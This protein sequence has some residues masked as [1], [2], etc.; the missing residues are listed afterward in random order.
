MGI[1]RLL[2]SE[3]FLQ[4]GLQDAGPDAVARLVDVES[5]CGKVCPHGESVLGSEER[6]EVDE[7]Q[8]LPL[9]VVLQPVVDI[10]DLRLLSLQYLPQLHLQVHGQQT[11]HQE[12]RLRGLRADG[13]DHAAAFLKDLLVGLLAR[14]VVGADHQKDSL[15]VVGCDLIESAEHSL[16]VVAHDAVVDDAGP[17]Q[18]FAPVASKLGQAIAQ[19]DDGGGVDIVAVLKLCYHVRIVF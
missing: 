7:G 15:W 12:M 14:H 8:L 3:N 6:V 10:D 16:G 13:V 5:V 19:H 9:A 2:C 1:L 4:I 17:S 11:L 18:F